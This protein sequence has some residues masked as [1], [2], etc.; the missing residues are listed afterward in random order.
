M[1]KLLLSIGCICCQ[2][3]CAAPRTYEQ[4]EPVVLENIQFRLTSARYTKTL[5]VPRAVEANATYLVLEMEMTN[6]AK[7]P[8][9]YIFR[10]ICRLIDEAGTEYTFDQTL[11]MM[12]DVQGRRSPNVIRELNPGVPITQT[13]IFDVP[14]K[15]Y[16][17]M[18]MVPNSARAGFMGQQVELTG[19][20]FFYRLT[21]VPA[22]EKAPP[23]G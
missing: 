20:H 17:L 10:P 16:R 13:F 14:R 6:V 15:V 5:Q 22:P 21:T 11:S 8:R 4:S 18:V 19:P 2:I 23:S 7:K 1:N 9:E 12:A 3:G